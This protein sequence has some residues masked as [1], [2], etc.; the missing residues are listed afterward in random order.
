[1][2]AADLRDLRAQGNCAS[3]RLCFPALGLLRSTVWASSRHLSKCRSDLG[4]LSLRSTAEVSQ[5]QEGTVVGSPD[6][7]VTF[8]TFVTFVVHGICHSICC[9]SVWSGSPNWNHWSSRRQL[10]PKD[11][12]GVMSHVYS[13]LFMWVKLCLLERVQAFVNFEIPLFELCLWFSQLS[14]DVVLNFPKR[15]ETSLG[16][17]SEWA[18]NLRLQIC[19]KVITWVACQMLC[20]DRYRECN[21]QSLSVVFAWFCCVQSGPY[22]AP[23]LSHVTNLV[24]SSPD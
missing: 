21:T 20:L 10:F 2:I 11:A 17:S 23:C 3:S 13:W 24:K 8:V 6:M 19:L 18:K 14:L 15:A 4:W 12:T 9:D 1:M 7:F 16:I 5:P 22:K